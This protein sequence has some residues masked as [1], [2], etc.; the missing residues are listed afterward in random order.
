MYCPS[1]GAEINANSTFCTHCGANLAAAPTGGAPPAPPV[2]AA[3]RTSG[4]SDNAAGAIAYLTII[5]AI[6]FLLLEPYNRRPFVRFHSYQSIAFCV[7][8]LVIHLVLGV[9]PVLGWIVGAFVSL[10]FFVLWLVTLFKASKGNWFKLPLIGDF[11]EQQA[12]RS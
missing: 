4:L 2:N 1:C 6:I 12:R 9:I 11:A 8:A 5:P 3:L 10:A 7:V